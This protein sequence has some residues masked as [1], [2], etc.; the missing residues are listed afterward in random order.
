MIIVFILFIYVLVFRP[1]VTNFWKFEQI[2][3]HFFLLLAQI[4]I[5]TLI[6]DDDRRHM[7]GRSRW[8][9]GYAVAFFMFFVI[10]WNTIVLI[11]KLIEYMMKCS[12]AKLAGGI[13]GVKVGGLHM[14]QDYEGTGTRYVKN[15]QGDYELIERHDI[16]QIRDSE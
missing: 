15:Q 4:L 14:D 11:W 1:A 3:I 6:Y 16:K 12:A 8:R 2:G 7:S 13:G 9:M 10:V 5:S